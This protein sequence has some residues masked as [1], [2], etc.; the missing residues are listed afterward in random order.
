[1]FDH[2]RIAFDRDLM[3]ATIPAEPGIV[4]PMPAPLQPDVDI[5]DTDIPIEEPSDPT[6]PSPVE[7]DIKDPPLT[8]VDQPYRM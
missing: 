4:P 2:A 5:P 7:P 6:R 3:E 8:P 1:M